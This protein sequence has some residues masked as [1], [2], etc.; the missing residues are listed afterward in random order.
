MVTSYL[1]ITVTTKRK[2][3]NLK[4]GHNDDFLN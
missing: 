4:N 3:D 1:F 2:E